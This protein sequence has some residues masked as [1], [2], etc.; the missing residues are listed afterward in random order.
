MFTIIGSHGLE[1][2]TMQ[3]AAAA[4]QLPQ[5]LISQLI[6]I[7]ALEKEAQLCEWSLLLLK[8]FCNVRGVA[9]AAAASF[10]I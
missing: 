8:N 1:H 4:C 3:L 10:Q 2:L 9:A 5:T 7:L 6:K